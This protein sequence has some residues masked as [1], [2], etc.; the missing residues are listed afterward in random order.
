M[1]IPQE[2]IEHLARL[3][4]LEITAEEKKKYS[5]QIS[6]ILDY[7]KKLR[8]L[9]TDNVEPLTHV[10]DLKNVT[11]EDK[12]KKIFSADKALAEAPE[13]EKRQ[14]KVKNVF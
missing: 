9:K 12:A 2:Q 7:F 4:R 3:A 6:L 13:L 1:A 5:K 14:I 10:V 11:R 8:E